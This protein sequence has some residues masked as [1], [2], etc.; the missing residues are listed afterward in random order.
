M[1]FRETVRGIF[2]YTHLVISGLLAEVETE[3]S[4]TNIECDC[5]IKS[6]KGKLTPGSKKSI[7]IEIKD[8]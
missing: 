8:S 3:K 1:T 7:K 2:M 5:D 4:W 6:Y